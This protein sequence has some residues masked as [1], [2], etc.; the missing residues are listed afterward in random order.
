MIAV[1]LL[2]FLRVLC[3]CKYVCKTRLNPRCVRSLRAKVWV[4]ACMR[5]YICVCVC[6]FVYVC[7]CV[8]VVVCVCVCARVR[9]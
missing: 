4:C 1:E 9:V 2:T 6:V 3:G 5:V 8:F 7:M